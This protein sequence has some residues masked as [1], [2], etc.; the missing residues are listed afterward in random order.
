MKIYF[1]GS[2]LNSNR[3]LI[4]HKFIKYRLISY[5]FYI[6]ECNHTQRS[7]WRNEFKSYKT[8]ENK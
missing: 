4:V 7:N 1:A 6:V 8:S 5:Y 2:G 3:V